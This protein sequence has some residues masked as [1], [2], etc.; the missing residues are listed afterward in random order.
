MVNLFLFYY[1]YF[2]NIAFGIFGS[3]TKTK[4]HAEVAVAAK[5]A[6]K[7]E[8]IEINTA[9]IFTTPFF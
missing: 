3:S 4:T 9:F 2:S 6:P 5:A 1:N 7:A 8:I